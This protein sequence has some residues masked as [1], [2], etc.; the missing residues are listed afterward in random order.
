MKRDLACS[1]RFHEVGVDQLGRRA[2]RETEYEGTS[3]C[4]C[5]GMD[6]K[7]DEVGDVARRGLRRV[8]D[9]EMPVGKEEQYELLAVTRKVSG[10]FE[11][12]LMM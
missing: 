9:D 7:D 1:I 12:Q 8:A 5:E 11:R 6:A 2:G 10:A 4:W 3:G